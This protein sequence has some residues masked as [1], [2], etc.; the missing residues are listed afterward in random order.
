MNETGAVNDR[1]DFPFV[2]QNGGQLC[3]TT[4]LLCGETGGRN[5]SPFAMPRK[6]TVSFFNFR[7]QVVREESGFD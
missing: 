5:L 1:D 3:V 7:R 2:G 6:F 4:T